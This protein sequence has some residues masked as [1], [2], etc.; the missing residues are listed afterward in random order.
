[1]VEVQLSGTTHWLY[2]FFSLPGSTQALLSPECM[3]P[4][5]ATTTARAYWNLMPM[6]LMPGDLGPFT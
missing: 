4:A 2:A 6:L 5:W 1:M 3:L